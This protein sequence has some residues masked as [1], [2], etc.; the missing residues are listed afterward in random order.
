MKKLNT[1]GF[2]AVEAIL[3]I[4]VIGILGFVG[5]RAYQVYTGQK[6]DDRQLSERREK[7]EISADT[8]NESKYILIEEW[9]VKIPVL[10]SST[11]V[12]TS[13]NFRDTPVGYSG[14][15]IHA[16]ALENYCGKPQPDRDGNYEPSVGH[17][18]RYKNKEDMDSQASA[19]SF[20]KEIKGYYYFFI[21]PQAACGKS[22]RLVN[23]SFDLQTEIG[24]E[25]LN[26]VKGI[27]AI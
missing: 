6:A 7:E 25:L 16:R 10:S 14:K 12:L 1:K 19:P 24:K 13:D 8:S 9:G 22:E 21:G 27:E 11:L 15:Y 20:I 2:G 17:I 3:I 4:V 5:Y 23:E 26:S 18:S